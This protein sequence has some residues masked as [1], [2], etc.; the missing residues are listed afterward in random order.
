MSIFH[1]NTKIYELRSLEEAI[2]TNDLESSK[3][4]MDE[5]MKALKRNNIWNLVLFPKWQKHIGSKWVFKW[6]M[7]WDGSIEKYK[8]HLDAKHYSLIV[9]VDGGEI[10]SL[11]KKWHPFDFNFILN[12]LM[13]YILR[14]MWKQLSFI[15]IWR[16]NL[17]DTTRALYCE[18]NMLFVL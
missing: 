5:E 17:D 14:C 4:S 7:G 10:F 16:E 1:L 13:I 12:L 8:A 2:G 9:R 11:I 3:I 15:E 6:S 18:R